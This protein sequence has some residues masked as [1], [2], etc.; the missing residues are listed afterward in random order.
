MDRRARSAGLALVGALTVLASGCTGPNSST[1][2]P[3]STAPTTG[4]ATGST[5]RPESTAPSTGAAPTPTPSAL[6]YPADVP[7]T[8]HDVK[9]GEKPPL[10]PAAA[11]PSTQAGAN[12]FAE[13]YLRTLDWAY[14]TTNAS[15]PKHYT[16]PS[17]G[18]CSELATGITKTAALHHWYLGGR[19]T[20]HPATVAPIGPVTA[21]AD[22]CSIVTVDSTAQS[23]VDRA[24]TVFNEEPA[25][26]SLRWKVCA[27]SSPTRWQVTYLAGAR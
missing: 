11:Q 25:H 1:V 22:F 4:T 13:F 26:P 9:L 2:P 5:A 8:G 12:A 20:I 10:Y 27:T 21:P 24:G 23:V 14:A 6:P 16:G 3:A 7:L 17:C 19:L 15:Y 18:L